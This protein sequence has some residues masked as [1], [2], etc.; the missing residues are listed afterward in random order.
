MGVKKCK[1]D[2]MR[3]DYIRQKG[4]RIIKMWECEWWSLLKTDA[5]VENHLSQNF[6]NK[7]HLSEEQLLQGIIDGKLCGN[8]Q[9]DFWFP[10]HLRRYFS[11]L[12]PII[13]NTVASKEDIGSLMREY[14]ERKISGPRPEEILYQKST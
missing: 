14:A 7:R 6:P 2:E 1:Q 5:V 11:N 3:R 13:K 9:C 10:E 12:P 4:F 8:F